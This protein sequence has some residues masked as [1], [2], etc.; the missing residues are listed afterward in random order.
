MSDSARTAH[1]LDPVLLSAYYDDALDESERRAVEE[2]LARCSACREQLAGYA[3]LG[4]AIRAGIDPPVPTRMNARVSALLKGKVPPRRPTRAAPRRPGRPSRRAWPL[5]SALAAVVLVCLI[6]GAYLF[7]L[8]F[9]WGA[10]GPTV[11]SAYPCNDPTQC[12]IAVQFSGPVDHAAVEQSIQID[13]P[14]A[15]TF[16]WQGNTLYVVPTAPLQQETS[17]TVSLRPASRPRR[18]VLPVTTPPTPIA[19]RFIAGGAGSPVA[20]AMSAPPT[21]TPQ[22]AKTVPAIA[23]AGPPTATATPTMGSSATAQSTPQSSPAEATGAGAVASA[24]PCATRPG[25]SFTA[26]LQNQ[27]SVA[28]RLGCARAPQATPQLVAEAFEQGEMLWRGDRRV[29]Y[30]LLNDGHWSSYPDTFTGTVT[31]TPGPREPVRG[32]GKVWHNT[33]KLRAAIGLTTETE[34]PVTG[35][36]EEFANG[37]LFAIDGQDGKQVIDVLYADGTWTRPTATPAGATATGTPSA[38]ASGTV[39]ATT[40]VTATASGTVTTTPSTSVT[41]GPTQAATTATPPAQQ[42]PTPA[43]STPSPAPTHAATATTGAACATMPVRGFGLVYSQHADVAAHLGCAKDHEIGA[44]STLQTFEHGVMIRRD[45]VRQIFVIQDNGKWAEY[46]DTYQD[47]EALPT[48]GPVPS[49]KFAPAHGFGKLWQEQAGLRQALGWATSAEQA[50]DGA[51]QSFAAGQMVWTSQRTI[52]V[53]YADGTWHSYP[54]T[55]VDPTATP[56]S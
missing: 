45:D 47:G 7:G 28:A 56:H 18:P 26:F 20:M 39:T 46:P 5:R 32:F 9:I 22:P 21:A 30:A 38:K 29:I 16:T 50:V 8:P 1:A 42:S 51:Y 55:F 53:L 37:T 24:T 52:Y 17:Y 54:D 43:Q 6:V 11:A 33:P 3:S 49:G 15:H 10:G 12:A 27:P 13:P 14:V 48:V 36:A 41:P 2:H 23:Q 35:S 34:H 19:L 25:A 4:G 40:T 44:Q 31:A